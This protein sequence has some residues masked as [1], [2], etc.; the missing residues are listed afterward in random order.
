MG[1]YKA[2]LLGSPRVG[3]TALF[4]AIKAIDNEGD[5][6][7]SSYTPSHGNRITTSS[8]AFDSCTKIVQLT[9]HETVKLKI[10]DTV[11]QERFNSVPN[12]YYRNAR[13]VLLT[14]NY[15]EEKS[16]RDLA[17]WLEYVCSLL[18]S[19]S[20]SYAVCLIGL[21]MD[22][23]TGDRPSYDQGIVTDEMVHQFRAFHTISSHLC[24]S[25]DLDDKTSVQQL[26]FQ[27]ARASQKLLQ[28][29]NHGLVASFQLS[30]DHTKLLS[31]QPSLKDHTVDNR[32]DA[33][34][35]TEPGHRSCPC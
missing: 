3:K 19:Y 6:S 22:D 10:F 21:R 26:L 8:V 24:F 33:D 17:S 14:F 25:I 1:E 11:G 29:H 27:L 31:T 23:S 13:F 12:Q 20:M 15:N 34:T 18:H 28:H 2:I 35:Q 16:L 30:E 5:V 32:V 4:N 7:G 9:G